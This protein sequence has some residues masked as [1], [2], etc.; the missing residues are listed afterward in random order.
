[1]SP[2]MTTCH[3]AASLPGV[4]GS[5][6]SPAH[7][8][9][10]KERQVWFLWRRVPLYGRDCIISS[11]LEPSSTKYFSLVFFSSLLS[12]LACVSH[13]EYI[14]VTS[15][16]G[17]KISLDFSAHQPYTACHLHCRDCAES[18][19][20]SDVF[21]LPLEP[22]W[23]D[24][25]HH[26]AVTAAGCIMFVVLGLTWHHS[27]LFLLNSPVMGLSTASSSGSSALTTEFSV[28]A[29][30]WAL[31]VVI[32]SLPQG[33][34][35][36][37]WCAD[38]IATLAAQIHEHCIVKYLSCYIYKSYVCAEHCAGTFQMAAIV[39]LFSRS[40]FMRVCVALLLHAGRFL[41]AT[42]VYKKATLHLLT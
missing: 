24:T 25:G 13:S 9:V 42:P 37:L 19:V 23:R 11:S 40:G 21:Q 28:P 4:V 16:L 7:P 10:S 2:W 8:S 22:L 29:T 33:S 39:A 18:F 5:F 27:R 34:A 31:I 26:W 36:P 15:A 41:P 35:L 12:W 1:M 32:A 20:H 38:F 30:K 6:S 14:W 3:K 17:K